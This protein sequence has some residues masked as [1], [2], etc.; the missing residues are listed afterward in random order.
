LVYVQFFCVFYV[1]RRLEVFGEY[2]TCVVLSAH[3]P[4][5]HFPIYVILTDC[6]V[7]DIDGSGVVIHVGLGSYVFSGLIIRE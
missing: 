5:S 2:V 4:D 7:A 1:E 3:S 6:V